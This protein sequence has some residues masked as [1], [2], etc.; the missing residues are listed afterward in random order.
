[1]KFTPGG[2]PIPQPEYIEKAKQLPEPE[3]KRILGYTSEGYFDLYLEG[4]LN[5][6]E[7]AAVVLMDREMMEAFWEAR[8]KAR[9]APSTPPASS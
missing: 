4:V 7:T 1:M 2:T 8:R 9:S 3:V 5:R 6:E